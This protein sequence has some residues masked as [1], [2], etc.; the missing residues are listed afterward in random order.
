MIMDEKCC[1]V[2]VSKTE[3]GYSVEITAEDKSCC[4]PA[5]CEP[6]K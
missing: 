5:C 2:K 1:E 4:L 6:R 3:K